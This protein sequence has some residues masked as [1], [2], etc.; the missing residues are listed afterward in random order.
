MELISVTSAVLKLLKSN[1]ARAV[2]TENMSLIFV[3][4]AV[5]KKLLKFKEAR[6]VHPENMLLIFVTFSVLKL[7]KSN[8]ARSL[9]YLN[10]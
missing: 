10:M 9:Q 3:T 2:H 1:E 8:E 6:A 5:L 7:L 4:L